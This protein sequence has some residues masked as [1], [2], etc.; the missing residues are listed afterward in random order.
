MCHSLLFSS[1]TTLNTP[2]HLFKKYFREQENNQTLAVFIVQS[3]SPENTW[4]L[5]LST[6]LTVIL[7]YFRTPEKSF[8]S[9]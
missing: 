1:V 8:K 2:R 5:P 6:F 4:H 9:F 3:L 7:G